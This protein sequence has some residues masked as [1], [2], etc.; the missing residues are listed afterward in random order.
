MKE[1]KISTYVFDEE[2]SIKLKADNINKAVK[3]F[4]N[5]SIVDLLKTVKV[6]DLHLGHSASLIEKK[7]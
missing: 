6:K 7:A 2:I 4:E 5:M 3:Q 1:Y